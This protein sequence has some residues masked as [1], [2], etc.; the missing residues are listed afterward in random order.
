MSLLHEWLLTVNRLW[1]NPFCAMF[2]SQ[3]WWLKRAKGEKIL[4][5]FFYL[6]VIFLNFLAAH[7][8]CPGVVFRFSF[9]KR[10]VHLPRRRFEQIYSCF[11]KIKIYFT[12]KQ[13]Q[14]Y[15]FVRKIHTHTRTHTHKCWCAR[16]QLQVWNNSINDGIFFF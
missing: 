7:N 4:I 16:G 14:A 15:T 3:L 5:S 12:H 11:S 10:S 1:C 13:T 8:H 6:L 9:F 2:D